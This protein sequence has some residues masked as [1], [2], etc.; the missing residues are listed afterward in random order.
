[1]FEVGD[2][3]IYGING[4]CRV[5]AIGNLDVKG[6]PKDRMFYTLVPI[7]S[8]GSKLFTPT[9][10]EKVIMRRVMNMEEAQALIDDIRNI[11]TIWIA[12]EKKR[13][14]IYKEALKKC[15]GREWVKII[16][17]VYLKK[18]LRISEGKKGIVS[19]E[20]YLRMA[21]D[22]LYG[23]LAIPLGMDRAQVE[24]YITDRVEHMEAEAELS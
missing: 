22:N 9:D 3:I 2:Y 7:Y 18:K 19:D 20:K 24:Q 15:D 17:T 12:D 5:E 14:M 21:E 11:E 1:M 10:N 4:V 13:E 8:K 16:K 23:E 6:I